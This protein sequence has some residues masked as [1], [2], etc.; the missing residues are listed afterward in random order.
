M[1]HC[2]M[3]LRRLISRVMRKLWSLRLIALLAFSTVVAF[4][5]LSALNGYPQYRDQHIGTAIEYARH[6]IDLLR[7]VVI[8]FNATGTPTILEVPLWQAV[9]ALFMTAFGEWLGWGNVVSLGILALGIYPL[10]QISRQAVGE[11]GAYWAVIAFLLQPLVFHMGAVAGTDGLS[12]VAAL[13]FFFLGTRML[14]KHSWVTFAAA[15]A[16]GVLTVLTKLPYFF[17]M[18]IALLGVLLVKHRRECI[19]W[20][21][22]IL[23]GVLASAVFFLWAWHTE[24][25]LSLAEFPFV[26]L[27][28]S[29]P[30]MWEWYFGTWEFRLNPIGWA[31]G[32][33]RALVALW[34]SLALAGFALAALL[35]SRSGTARTLLG[36]ALITTAVF[37]N[38]IL[39][40]RHY[41]LLFSPAV[42]ILMGAAIDWIETRAK[43]ARYEKVVPYFIAACLGLGTVQG[44]L[45]MEVQLG[46]DPYVKKVAQQVA[47]HTTPE[48]RILIW[49][50]GWGGE[51][52]MRSNRRG[53]SFTRR[54]LL[55]DPTS[56]QRLRALGYNKV[57]LI[58]DSPLL[59][60]VVVTNPG[61]A[62]AQRGTYQLVH[63]TLPAGTT[64]IHQNA[65][66]YIG[67]L[68]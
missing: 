48:D 17:F 38:L 26:D 19:A 21:Q 28:M 44:L 31:K 60:A 25:M 67:V 57:V 61:R 41:Y 39:V 3:K 33:W 46:Y 49:G 14:D 20:V 15:L 9:T 35:S 1:R 62:E 56:L 66:V 64:S 18:G 40:H 13:W 52:L 42:A 12:I 50:G 59:W 10:F 43:D 32:A 68:P 58:S 7:P 63:E 45:G 24:A 6:G 27:R 53:L 51:I 55:K 2:R 34:G 36:A 65:D 22:L 4:H 5:M 54:D 30:F 37:S 23:V 11:R 16:G 8:G 29:N 47:K